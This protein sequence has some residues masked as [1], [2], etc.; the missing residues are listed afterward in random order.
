MDLND[1]LK[2]ETMVEEARE[3]RDRDKGALDQL[4][5]ELKKH[6][7]SSLKDAKKLLALKKDEL[8]KDEQVTAKL[9]KE[10]E[11]EWAEYL[12]AAEAEGDD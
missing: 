3:A 7:C 12:R 9:H 6:G 10:F 4:K 1:F 11:H 2:I 5:K 8:G